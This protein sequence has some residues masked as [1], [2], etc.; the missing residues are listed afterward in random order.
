MT[1]NNDALS[2]LLSY[3]VLKPQATSK[4]DFEFAKK[5][6]LM[7]DLQYQE[8]DEAIAIIQREIKKIEKKEVAD[9]YLAS[10]YSVGKEYRSTLPVV[11]ILHSFPIHGFVPYS[12]ENPKVCKICASSNRKK[13][14]FSF[15]N[16]VRYKLGGIVTHDV[17][18]YAFYLQQYNLMV[19]KKPF[20]KDLEI[21]KLILKCFADAASDETPS[22]IQKKIKSISGFKSTEEERKVFIDG[23]GFCSILENDDKKG[24]LKKYTCLGFAPRKSRSSD[25]SFPVDWWMG[26][27]GINMDAIDYWFRKYQLFK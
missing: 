15:L 22:D 21:F 6:G 4:E 20:E 9:S 13:V 19:A 16:M 10:F 26:K 18:A 25:W 1:V 27:D 2:V 24:F 5:E 8:H 12:P 23:L 7:F 3:N 11:A 17:Y 14:D